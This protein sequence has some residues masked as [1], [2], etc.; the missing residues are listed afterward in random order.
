MHQKGN[1][2]KR[3]KTQDLHLVMVKIMVK[4]VNLLL[5][6]LRLEEAKEVAVEAAPVEN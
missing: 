4:L 1:L 3:T 5:V 6:K 2:K